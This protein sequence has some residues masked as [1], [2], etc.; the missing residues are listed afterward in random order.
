MTRK[1]LSRIVF[2]CL[3]PAA[4]LCLTAS[5]TIASDGK[6][7]HLSKPTTP[8]ATGSDALVL[9]AHS[10]KS[11]RIWN[12]KPARS[13]VKRRS[14]KDGL[15]AKT[16][17]NPADGRIQT[18]ELSKVKA[19]AAKP[20]G[21]KPQE[22]QEQ[23]QEQEQEESP[24]LFVTHPLRGWTILHDGRFD[25]D[26]ESAFDILETERVLGIGQSE[27]PQSV[28]SGV[29][30]IQATLTRLANRYPDGIRGYVALDWEDPFFEVLHQGPTH[31]KYES[32]L[33][34]V[35]DFVRRFKEVFP[36]TLVTQYNLPAI[37]YWVKNREGTFVSWID[38]SDARRSEIFEELEAMRPL[39]DEMDWFVPRF[40]D[41]VPTDQIPEDQREAQVAAECEHR[42]AIVRWL[43]KYV[44]NSDR[45][46]RKIIPVTRTNWVGGATN[47]SEWVQME[48]PVQEY[49]D[50]QVMPA[51]L[52]GADGVK[53]WQGWEVWMLHLAFV[54][55]DSISTELR[56]MSLDHLRLLGI[57]AEDEV[58]DWTNATQKR[59]IQRALGL[60]QMPYLSAIAMTMRSGIV[61]PI[62][63][64]AAEAD[65]SNQVPETGSAEDGKKDEPG[66]IRVVPSNS[67]RMRITVQNVRDASKLK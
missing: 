16:P 40:Y 54:P 15:P 67:S 45:P 42:A 52:N 1:R 47:Y 4:A 62:A 10:E 24:D 56:S 2:H 38:A 66:R 64:T 3:V 18:V 32:T 51:L 19:V 35:T 37:P 31:P 57:I 9:D 58:P 12:D 26:T 20:E 49:I 22:T 13:S 6:R 21:S 17:R 7:V 48:I 27:D 65:E 59:F 61:P 63:G 41:F 39:L 30:D 53:I 43:R 33:E 60:R 14:A 28:E 55:P 25:P 46:E 50:E 5:I 11:F 8:T 23:E 44:D 34:N 36:G 29:I